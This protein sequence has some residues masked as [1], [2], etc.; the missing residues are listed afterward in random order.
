MT[1]NRV[2]DGSMQT[3]VVSDNDPVMPGDMIRVE[4]REEPMAVSTDVSSN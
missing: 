3:L 1:V 2:I 4:Q